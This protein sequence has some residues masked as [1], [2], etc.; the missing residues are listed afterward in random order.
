M[1]SF[2][3]YPAPSGLICTGILDEHQSFVKLIKFFIWPYFIA[4]RFIAEIQNNF[5]KA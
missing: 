1:P 3:S 5:R 4:F 2:Y